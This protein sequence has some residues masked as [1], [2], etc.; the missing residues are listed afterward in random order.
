MRIDR[1]SRAAS[2]A[3][4]A[5]LA[6]GGRA[7]PARGVEGGAD[8]LRVEPYVIHASDG[9]DHDA[10]LLRLRVP[11]SHAIPGG[12]RITI[13]LLRLRSTA[14]EP[15]PPL[16]F[17]P[18]GPGYPASL[19]ARDPAYLRLFDRLRAQSDVLL[20]DQ[21][22]SGLSEPNLQCVTKAPL[23]LDAFESE[24]ALSIALGSMIR[25][26]VRLVRDDGVDPTAYNTVESAE[27]LED[28]R[29]ALGVE[30]LRLLGVSYGTELVLETIR[31][32][33]DRIDRAV[34]AG[35]RGPDQAY[36]LPVA[37]DFQLRRF[38]ALVSADPKL[39]PILPD[40]AGAVRRALET[41]A[42][43]P[44]T[45]RI[46]DAKSGKEVRV[47][48]GTVGLQ[49]IVASDMSDWVR[50]AFLPAMFAAMQRGDS[51]LFARRVAELYNT[52]GGGI[53]VMQ[54]AVDCASG[55]SPER[56]ATVAR[57]A[58]GS[59]MGNIRN[60]LLNPAFC[61]LVGRPD[62]GPVFREPIYSDVPALFVSGSLDGIT[63]PFQ[64]EE[65]CWG[66]PRGVHLVV[67]NGWHE[68]LPFVAVQDAVVDFLGGAD[69]R[70]R[71]VSVPPP[72][73]ADVER[74]KEL[75]LR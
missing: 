42:W 49:A 19:V 16:V 57:Q 27:D 47:R 36:Q 73:F 4:F 43:R 40:F 29:R 64:A 70:G 14:L 11:E 55:G 37:T 26:C 44:A 1:I 62:L 3:L 23:P 9:V 15:G 61:D 33:G 66:F 17:L 50:G 12:R 24:A 72:K 71:R 59:P 2:A 53:S 31:R 63:P 22:G 69:V 54:V 5:L 21:R 46:R 68:T 39:A 74:A 6:V 18:G 65:V 8:S 56:I 7:A 48:L 35:T 10:E 20:L 67:E 30:K 45:V 38:S 58:K 60:T 32:H 75:L 13:A 41:L 51:T 34:L 28:L 25:P 52:Q